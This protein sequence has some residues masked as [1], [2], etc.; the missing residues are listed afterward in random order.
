MSN[1]ILNPLPHPSGLIPNPI[2]GRL[3]SEL[4]RKCMAAAD[5]D[6]GSGATPWIHLADA[7]SSGTITPME[8]YDALRLGYLP[9]TLAIRK[10]LYSHLV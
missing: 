7:V 3:S 8:A 2:P 5:R 10:S 6:K 1:P 4:Y 9:A